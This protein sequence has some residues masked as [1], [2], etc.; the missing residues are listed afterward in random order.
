MIISEKQIL[1]LIKIAE[2]AYIHQEYL[3][4]TVQEVRDIRLILDTIY[5]Q[6]SEE[7]KDIT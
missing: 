6:Q 1:K 2:E 7:L 3:N 5:N 4:G